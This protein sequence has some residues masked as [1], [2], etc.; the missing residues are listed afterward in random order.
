MAETLANNVLH[1]LVSLVNE[2]STKSEKESDNQSGKIEVETMLLA[3]K[4][5][6]NKIIWNENESEVNYNR[7][8]GTNMWADNSVEVINNP[9]ISFN[10]EKSDSTLDHGEENSSNES[11]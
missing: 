7:Q 11:E 2:G 5:L 3:I 10:E 1:Q 4:G 8:P 9:L 6:E